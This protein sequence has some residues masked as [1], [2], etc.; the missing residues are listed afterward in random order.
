L[1]RRDPFLWRFEGC[2][3]A[4]VSGAFL[5]GKLEV[6]RVVVALARLAPKAVTPLSS[7]RFFAAG[8]PSAAL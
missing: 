4:I 1:R 3:P 5:P 2:E 6:E 7:S 8:S